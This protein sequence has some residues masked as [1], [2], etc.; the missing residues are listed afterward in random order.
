MLFIICQ[1]KILGR[2][3]QLI[4][5]FSN[6]VAVNIVMIIDLLQSLDGKM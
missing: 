6:L 3:K 1:T 5:N 2:A 4:W